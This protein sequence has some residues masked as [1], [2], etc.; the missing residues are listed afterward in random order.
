MDKPLKILKMKILNCLIIIALCIGCKNQ[1][2]EKSDSREGG[3]G[4][5]VS[6]EKTGDKPVENGVEMTAAQLK[7]AQ[8]QVGKA[9]KRTLKGILKVN[10]TIDVPPQNLVSI[11]VPLGGYLKKTDLLPGMPVKKGQIIAIVEDAAYVQLE[12]DYLTAD[13]RLEY[14]QQ[15]LARQTELN[16]QQINA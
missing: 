1:N 4:S 12:Q 3:T 14:L 16:Q 8:I 11:S 9:E 6:T 7:N 15:E 2:A 13:A 5:S 10:G